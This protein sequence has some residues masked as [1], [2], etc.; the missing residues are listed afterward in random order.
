MGQGLLSQRLKTAGLLLALFA[1][2]FKA[3]LPPGF[4]LTPD[5]GRAIVALCTIDGAMTMAPP[6]GAPADKGDHDERGAS[7]CVFAT[8]GA[9]DVPAPAPTPRASLIV[10]S[11]FEWPSAPTRVGQGLAAPPPWPTGP[12]LSI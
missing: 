11:A 7:P 4:M 1:L 5:H 8:V 9:I 2:T 3:L 10:A 6:G 12:P